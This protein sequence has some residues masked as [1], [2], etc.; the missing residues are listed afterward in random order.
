[1]KQ[2][3]VL[4]AVLPIMLIF[5]MQFALEQQNSS[6][7]LRFENYVYTSK[8][9]AKQEG[10]FSDV[11]ISSL[12]EKIGRD[13]NVEKERVTFEGTRTPKYRVNQ[14]DERELIYYK[15]SVPIE[16]IMSGGS[17]FGISEEYNKGSYTIESATASECLMP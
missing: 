3:I 11:N 17:M 15:V 8:E 4:I 5:I 9:I 14:F 10:Y 2:L 13:F 7:I 6:R 16:K 1:M 12:K